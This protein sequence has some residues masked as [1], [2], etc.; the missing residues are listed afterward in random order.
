MQLFSN[1]LK[2]L[3]GVRYETTAGE[4]EGP[5][6]DPGAAFVRNANG[7]FARNAQGQ[8]IRRPE[9]GAVNSIEELMLTRKERAP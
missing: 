7:T 6:F 3:T 5:L 1:R 2:I 4:G 8:R 9:A